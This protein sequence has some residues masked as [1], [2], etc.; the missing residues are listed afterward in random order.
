MI[1]TRA[2]LASLCIRNNGHV[3]VGATAIA[4]VFSTYMSD[5]AHTQTPSA[6]L[7]LS[8]LILISHFL[9]L[10]LSRSCLS[11]SLVYQSLPLPLSLP[12]SPFPSLPSLSA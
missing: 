7:P 1:D 5:T 10:C 3:V 2:S 8:L 6:L 4:D 11:L 12:V 9:S